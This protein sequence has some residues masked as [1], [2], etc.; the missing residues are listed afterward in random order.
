MIKVKRKNLPELVM[1]IVPWLK[2]KDIT[3][4]LRAFPSVNRNSIEIWNIAHRHPSGAE[5]EARAKAEPSRIEKLGLMVR[6]V[7]AY[8]TS[9]PA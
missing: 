8:R 6:A 9:N 7:R 5:L 2:A 3:P 4:F 1:S